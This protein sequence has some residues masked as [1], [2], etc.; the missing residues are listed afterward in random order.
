MITQ[1]I[2]GC[3]EV[4]CSVESVIYYNNHNKDA[5]QTEKVFG[6]IHFS[7]FLSQQFEY[8]LEKA[9]PQVHLSRFYLLFSS[10]Q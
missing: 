4:K 1:D 9:P 8:L 3:R 10:H 5:Y 7:M 6:G 2:R